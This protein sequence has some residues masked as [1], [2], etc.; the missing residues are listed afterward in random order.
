MSR[1][2]GEEANEQEHGERL[3]STLMVAAWWGEGGGCL[4]VLIEAA[5]PRGN[6]HTTSSLNTHPPL[7]PFPRVSRLPRPSAPYSSGPP[8]PPHVLPTTT[9][10]CSAKG[11]QKLVLK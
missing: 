8:R 3:G 9:P 7:P 1:G 2:G 5:H 6:Q 10:T 4:V 11:T